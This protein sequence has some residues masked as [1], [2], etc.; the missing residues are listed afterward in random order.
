MAS[1]IV[2]GKT[3]EADL[4]V[5]DKDGLMFDSETFW[6]EIA[7]AR[8]RAISKYCSK[9][10]VLTWASRMSVRTE[11]RGDEV[12]AVRVDPVGILA[13]APPP[14]EIVILAAFLVETRGLVWHEARKLAAKLFEEADQDMDLTRALRAQPGFV[15][16]MKRLR[17]LGIPYGVATSDTVERT[18]DSMAL[19]DC[20]EPVRFVVTADD[21]AFGKPAPDMLKLISKRE[22]VPLS[23]VVMIGDS[24]LDVQLARAAGSIGI[25][26]TGSAEM[27][28][29]M[30]P[31]AD[32][33]V[34][35]LEAIEVEGR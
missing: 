19:F 35:T 13:V 4:L 17:E 29:K 8:I 30:I 32:E 1:V 6:V 24:Y 15:A 3:Y 2:N 31:F 12:R 25:G 22:N 5:F 16:L 9:E 26:V 21:V 18:R 10:Q 7:N 14:E 20:W 33:I 34:G 27:R 23:R 11:V 28:E